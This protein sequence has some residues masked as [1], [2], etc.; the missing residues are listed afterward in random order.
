MG[1]RVIATE[2]SVVVDEFNR[3]MDSAAARTR[4]VGTEMERVA[5]QKQAF[6]LLGTSMLAAGGLMAAGLGVAVA[7]AADFNEAMSFVAATGDDARD[8]FGQL[9]EAALE[10]GADTVFSA[11]ES[12]NAIEEMAK[13]GLS[14]ADILGGGLKGALDLAA[15]GG[16]G[17]ARAAE[18][19]STTMQQFSL[20]GE[21]ATHIADLLAAGAGKAM[22]D[23]EDFA[24]ALNQ[25][26]LV[27]SQFGISAEETTGTL[28]AFAQAG[29]LG[30]DA[31]TSFRTMLLRLANPTE[32]V[33]TLMAELGLE[34]YDAQGN[35][36]G[37][38]GLAGELSTS[39]RG[40]TQQQKD[41]TLA[42]IFGQDAIRGANILLREG[43]DGIR[44][45]TKQVDDQGY[46]AETAATRLDNLKGD[47]EALSGALDT[48]F[49]T[50]GD[51]ATGPLRFFTQALTGMVDGFT[52]M[53]EWGQ[54]TVFWLGAVASA[55]AL[56]GGSFLVAV[57]KMAEYR[58][59]L[60]T[61]G[62][63]A[64]RT[65]RIVSA[66]FKALGVGVAI[67][68]S[69]EL[70]KIWR[71]QLQPSA[72]EL[73]NAL[74]TAKTAQ[75]LFNKSTVAWNPLDIR[76][77]AE[78][79]DDFRRALELA[80]TEA[81][82]F[83]GWFQA[84][85]LFGDSE[86]TLATFRDG[87]QS[88]AK[89]MANAPQ[90]ITP[91]FERLRDEFDATDKEL[92]RLIEMSP[93]LKAALTEQATEAGLAADSQTLLRI[94]LGRTGGASE[95]AAKKTEELAEAA[96]AAEVDLDALRDALAGV[97]GTA[98]SMSEAI[99]DAH[100]SINALTEAADAEGVTLDG[101]NDASIKLRDSMRD[102]EQAH[103][104]S[105]QAIIDNGGTFEAARDEWG[106]GREAILLQLQAM[107][108]SRDEAVRW[109]DQN[110]GSASAVVGA[111]SSVKTAASQ[112]TSPP[113][114]SLSVMGYAETYQ[115]LSN[116]QQ[117]LRDVSNNSQLRIA[118]GVGGQG[119]TTAYANGGIEDY[120]FAGGGGINSGIFKGGPPIYKFAEPETGWEAFISGKP[121]ERSRNIGLWQETGRRLGVESGGGS[122]VPA[123]VYVQNPFTGEY[124]L[125]KTAEVA[126]GVVAAAQYATHVQV[127][128]GRSS[129]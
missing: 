16:L 92:Q 91:T 108:M 87:W 110:M 11:T 72:E 114:I 124:L 82:G 2:L 36:I 103:R 50:M 41:T 39:L 99:D 1:K 88:L 26:G 111:L 8:S 77:M 19:M 104:D 95:D 127:T 35:F 15:A 14:A 76:P 109:A 48:M 49:I 57:P 45:W 29:M 107:G 89:E 84:N 101:T 13:A 85:T 32:E 59:A 38:A 125:A 86:K 70:A 81:T 106:K 112:I 74:G 3:N 53:P 94:A 24:Q 79:V 96:Q 80:E 69:V 27:A 31:G 119:G 17:V 9:R 52:S 120:S 51:G 105:A 73:A 64:Q 61:L 42:M 66:S 83:A 115:Y 18:V 6:Q 100:G 25:A 37:M 34:A 23:V 47:I 67:A 97:G 44:R 28:A 58:A 78:G 7:K 128:S 56:G 90:T 60:E 33:K 71:D 121:S 113:P 116:I 55:V 12:A 93:E 102:V 117:K 62:P 118:T 123:A 30:S 129:L 126:G 4:T 122:S 75:D 98:M 65:S 43:E 10:A 63:T 40:M 68:A 54:Q 22:G 5:Q 46:A 20:S 21:D